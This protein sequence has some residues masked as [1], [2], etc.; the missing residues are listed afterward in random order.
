MTKKTKTTI[1]HEVTAE[2]IRDVVRTAS[3]AA[4]YVAMNERMTHNIGIEKIVAC[5]AEELRIDTE[6]DDVDFQEFNKL[7]TAAIG[8]LRNNRG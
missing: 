8:I 5:E 4:D 3:Q 1:T 2:H 6:L 7:L